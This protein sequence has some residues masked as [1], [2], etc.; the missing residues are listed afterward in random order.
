MCVRVTIKIDSTAYTK[1]VQQFHWQEYQAA[2]A[3]CVNS[4]TKAY[5]TCAQFI[6]T[7]PDYVMANGIESLLTCLL[8]LYIVAVVAFV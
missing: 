3:Q 8:S 1:R 2:V 7:L 6:I 5:L 4:L